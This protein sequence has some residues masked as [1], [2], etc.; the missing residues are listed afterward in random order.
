[1]TSHNPAPNYYN[2]VARFFLA[3]NKSGEPLDLLECKLN[4]LLRPGRPIAVCKLHADGGLESRPYQSADLELARS[5]KWHFAFDSSSG[6]VSVAVGSRGFFI[7]PDGRQ[8]IT[9]IS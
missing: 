1:M 8:G 4:S 9:W 5:I 3:R 7:Q 2:L 6:C